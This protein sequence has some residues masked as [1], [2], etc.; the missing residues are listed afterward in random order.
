MTKQTKKKS[1]G[2]YVSKKVIAVLVLVLGVALLV[3][4][5][6]QGYDKVYDKV[7]DSGFVAGANG[8]SNE[9]LARVATCDPLPINMVDENG[10]PMI[11]QLTL[12][13]CLAPPVQ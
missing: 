2:V 10:N 1:N 3:F 9:I 13:E 5:G 12:L 8:V 6:V 4:G 11:V 7:Y